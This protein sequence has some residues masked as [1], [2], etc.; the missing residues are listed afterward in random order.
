MKRIILFIG[1]FLSILLG[2]EQEGVISYYTK[3]ANFTTCPLTIKWLDKNLA[4]YS[5]KNCWWISNKKNPNKYSLYLNL[6]GLLKDGSYIF[7]TISI[8]PRDNHDCS[9]YISKKTIF[10]QSCIYLANFFAKDGYEFKGVLNQNIS[11]LSNPKTGAR[12]F[13]SPISGNKCYIETQ[14]GMY[15]SESFF[16]K[17]KIYLN[18]K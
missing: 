12:M 4:N 6:E 8:E 10:N 17:N 18:D 2:K 15:N 16:R 9:F 7:I 3:Q 11:V 1:L 5:F 14:D 13:L